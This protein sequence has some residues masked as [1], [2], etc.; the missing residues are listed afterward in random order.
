LL[1]IT[2]FGCSV[3]QVKTIIN[4]AVVLAE[5]VTTLM[6]TLA[7]P[8]LTLVNLIL[9][10]TAPVLTLVAFSLRLANL[11]LTLTNL[12]LT[13][14]NLV[15]TSTDVRLRLATLVLRLETAVLRVLIYIIKANTFVWCTGSFS[16]NKLIAMPVRD[17]FL[18]ASRFI[19][20][21]SLCAHIN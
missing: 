13:L 21:L 17:Y 6:L 19:L 9:T 4:I 8:P 16:N 20:R 15:T 1:I 5:K 12:S 2:R 3:G 10:L 18:L 7:A 11:K 14:T